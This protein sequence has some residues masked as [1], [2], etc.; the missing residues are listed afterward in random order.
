[1]SGAELLSRR[2]VLAVGTAFAGGLIAGM[3]QQAAASVITSYFSQGVALGFRGI[4]YGRAE[5]FKLPV[6]VEHEQFDPESRSFGPSCQ[7]SGGPACDLRHRK[8]MLFDRTSR[9]VADPRRWERELF[10]R[11]PYVQPGT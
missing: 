9:V 11:V 8:T 2:K 10:A 1:M 7:Q 3:P 5:R 4:R 6:A